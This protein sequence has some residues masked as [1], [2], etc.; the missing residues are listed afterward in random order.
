M[1]GVG[2]PIETPAAPN[3]AVEV[4]FRRYYRWL[5]AAL[6]RRYG[7]E[8]AEDLAQETYLRM[9]RLDDAVTVRHPRALLMQVARNA[10]TD[11]YRRAR[12]ETEA[13]VQTADIEAFP[14]A[15]VQHQ[16]LMIKQIVLALPPKLR[17]VFVLSQLEGLTHQEIARLL[18]ISVKTV[19]WR[20]RKALARCVSAMQ[21]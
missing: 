16:A 10:A 1:D 12:R 20:I 19:E 7:A 21:D 14:T 18:G 2:Q 11:R 6:R 9:A 5:A 8:E 13:T 17:D 4:L 3:S 15:P